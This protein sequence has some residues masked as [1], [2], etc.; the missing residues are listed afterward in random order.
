MFPVA[1]FFRL[2][3]AAL[4]YRPAEVKKLVCDSVNHSLVNINK[5]VSDC[6]HIFCLILI[7]IILCSSHCDEFQ[8]QAVL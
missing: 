4:S 8:L 7:V 3:V 6:T 2:T 5:C 1:F